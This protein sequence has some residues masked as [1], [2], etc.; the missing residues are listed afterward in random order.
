[1]MYKVHYSLILIILISD[2]MSMYWYS[3][4]Q[5]FIKIDISRI[6]HDYPYGIQCEILTLEVNLEY[7][8]VC[9][10]TNYYLL[11]TLFLGHSDPLPTPTAPAREEEVNVSGFVSVDNGL[12]LL[13]KLINDIIIS[14]SLSDD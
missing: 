1:M 8:T 5:A 12:L 2:Q 6:H 7:H 10:V 9:P 3:P 4:N 13:H 14:K 11:F